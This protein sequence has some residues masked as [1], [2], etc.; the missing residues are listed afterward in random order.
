M[1]EI[2]EPNGI[3]IFASGSGT[4]AENIIRFFQ[5]D[6]LARVNLVVSSNEHAGVVE[7]ARKLKVPVEFIEKKEFNQPNSILPML[8]EYATE[9]IVLAGFL[10]LVPEYLVREYE[11]RILNIHPALLPKYGG[12]G[13]YGMNVHRA[14]LENQEEYSGITIHLVNESYD[15]GKVVAQYRLEVKKD[16]SP[17]E[18]QENIH[19]LEYQFFPSTIRD[20][21]LKKSTNVN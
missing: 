20:F 15:E 3:T 18:L 12:K 8:R 6:Q 4:N 5:N 13:M 16:W 14:V 9:F 17:D 7:R 11:D 10:W 19:K 2:E 1:R 21:I